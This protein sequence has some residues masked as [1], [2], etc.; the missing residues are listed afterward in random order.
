[1]SQNKAGVFQT[2]Y[3]QQ[4]SVQITRKQNFPL[5]SQELC[6]FMRLKFERLL[7]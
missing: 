6:I 3:I 2:A 7:L 5:I 1:M 4:R